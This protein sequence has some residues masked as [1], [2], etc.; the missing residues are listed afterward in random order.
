M[1]ARLPRLFFGYNAILPHVPLDAR[2]FTECVRWL[3][4]GSVADSIDTAGEI[5][6]CDAG[7]WEKRGMGVIQQQAQLLILR[8]V[9]DHL[10]D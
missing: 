4:A 1:S 7:V 3:Y 2:G 10:R 6:I 5:L 8:Q 9:V